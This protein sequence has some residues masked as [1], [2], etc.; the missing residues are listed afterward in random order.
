[1]L[2]LDR[3]LWIS[4]VSAGGSAGVDGLLIIQSRSQQG[5]HSLGMGFFLSL[6]KNKV[7]KVPALSGKALHFLIVAKDPKV[8]VDCMRLTRTASS[9]E[10][11]SEPQSA[12]HWKDRAA[13]GIGQVGG[14]I[15]MMSWP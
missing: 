15:L 14:K 1:M 7:G 8:K 5:E 13:S 10:I 6:F 12:Q 9:H 3:L 4:P 11:R 2:W